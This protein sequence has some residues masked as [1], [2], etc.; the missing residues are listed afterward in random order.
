MTF[1]GELRQVFKGE[2][3]SD[4]A[5]LDAASGDASIFQ[6]EPALVVA[7]KDSADLQSLVTFVSENKK[8]YPNLSLTARAAGTDMGGGPLTS[9][10]VVDF[11][12]HF[13]GVINVDETRKEA[14][15]LPGTY[16]RDF[17][18]ATLAKGL[19]LPCYTASRELNTVGGMV[20]NNSAGEKTLT[21]G[22][23]ARYVHTL[24]VVLQDGIEYEF[25][26][27]TRTELE[28]KKSQANYEG[29]IYRRV[30][31]LIHQHHDAI[32]SAKPIVS[33]NSAGYGIWNVWDETTD[34]FDMTQLFVGSQ[35]TLGLIS[36]ITF[37]L[38]KPKPASRMLVLFLRPKHFAQLGKIVNA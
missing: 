26:R 24:K 4:K 6:I 19:L 33:K 35:G 32:K 29:E 9:S 21:Y 18:K 12:P 13:Q 30:E 10:V 31:G 15:V 8:H 27:L 17:E 28:A 2:I 1:E 3:K 23:T 20:A 37:N 16:Y 7:P 14:T 25:K 5:S 34:T 22:Q 36:E 11:M 38:V